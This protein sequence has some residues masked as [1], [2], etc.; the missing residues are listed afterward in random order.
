M[1]KSGFKAETAIKF[2]TE[3]PA[4]AIKLDNCKGFIKDGF[5]ADIVLLDSDFNVLKT[6][7]NGKQVFSAQ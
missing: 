3:N 2:L 4:K 5:D 6:F 7:V 1:I